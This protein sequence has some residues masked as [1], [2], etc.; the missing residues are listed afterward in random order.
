M[1]WLV[2][3]AGMLGRLVEQELIEAELAY[4][5]SGRECDVTEPGSIEAASPEVA[6]RWVINCTGYTAVDTAESDVDSAWRVNQHG[7]AQLANY[8]R[9]V[10]ERLLHISTDYVFD[11][12]N[13][14][15][16]GERAATAPQNVYGASKLAGEQVLRSELTEHVIIRTAWLYAEH[17]RNFLRTILRML[18]DNGEL[19]IVSDQYGS[20]TYARDL[21]RAIVTVVESAHPGYGTFHF[22]NTGVASWHEFADEI[23]SCAL[24]LGLTTARKSI[25]PVSSDRFPTAAARPKYS[26][27]LCSRIAE[28]YPVYLRPWQQALRDCME[29]LSSMQPGGAPTNGSGEGHANG[30][31]TNGRHANGR[32][33]TSGSYAARR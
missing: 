30:Q 17:G 33:R 2:G 25:L 26:V 1:I 8:C 6:P 32:H 10:R 29:R 9:A 23:Q 27:L 16:Y 5:A 12:A 28:R 22:V 13:R 20:P 7:V 11:G 4:H 3:R 21:A 31:Y 18:R 15:G 24:D 14:K 19:T